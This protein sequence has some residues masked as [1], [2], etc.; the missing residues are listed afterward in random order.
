MLIEGIFGVGLGTVVIATWPTVPWD[1]ITYVA[2]IGMFVLA[3]AIQP[4]G[5]VAWLTLDVFFR[6][7]LPEEC[8]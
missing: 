4:I 6:P 8:D 1:M 5:R 3:I 7:I 2:A